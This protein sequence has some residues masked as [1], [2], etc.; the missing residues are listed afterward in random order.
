MLSFLTQIHAEKNSIIVND[1]T[2]KVLHKYWVILS[3]LKLYIIFI[4]NI[5]YSFEKKPI[6]LSLMHYITRCFSLLNTQLYYVIITYHT[7]QILETGLN[8]A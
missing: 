8:V 3:L 2:K 7:L 1:I 4:L 5:I 6:I